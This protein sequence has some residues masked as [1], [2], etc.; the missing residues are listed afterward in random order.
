MSTSYIKNSCVSEGKI[1]IHGWTTGLE[2]TAS[3]YTDIRTTNTRN[4][5][6]YHL[7]TFLIVGVN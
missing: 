1:I 2:L 4:T 6:F 3:A 7:K 5:S